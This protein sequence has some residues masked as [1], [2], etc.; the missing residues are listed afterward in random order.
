MCRVIRAFTVSRLSP[1]VGRLRVGRDPCFRHP[2]FR[3]HGD[4]F[5]QIRIESGELAEQA[6]KDFEPGAL[7]L[8]PFRGPERVIVR[9][10]VERSGR[11]R[12]RA[13]RGC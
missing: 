1:R 3:L 12:Q 11:V 4:P 6:G 7:G 13:P 2:E 9:E 8:P 5:I 10:E